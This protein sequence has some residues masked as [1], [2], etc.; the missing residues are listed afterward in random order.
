MHF[1][2]TELTDGERALRREI[3]AFLAAE[4]GERAGAIGAALQARDIS[5]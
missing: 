3:R 1:E 5:A 2:A 4:L